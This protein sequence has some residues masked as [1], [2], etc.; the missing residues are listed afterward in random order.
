MRKPITRRTV[1]YNA[2]IVSYLQS[3][4][5][6]RQQGYTPIPPTQFATPLVI[7]VE[8]TINYLY[9]LCNVGVLLCLS[10]NLPLYGRTIQALVC[11]VNLFT[12]PQTKF[13]AL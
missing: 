11:A 6:S 8:S 2:S 10:Y 3:Q 13:A 9:V 1:D 5:S 7:S 12:L 4:F